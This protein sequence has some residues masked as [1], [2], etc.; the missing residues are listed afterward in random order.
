MRDTEKQ[1]Q[2]QREKQAFCKEPDLGLD[3]R[4]PESLPEPK[5]DAQPLSHPEI[6][7]GPLALPSSCHLIDGSREASQSLGMVEILLQCG[8]I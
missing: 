7:Y 5:A 4:T 8:R 1:R 3:P 2:R 6:S